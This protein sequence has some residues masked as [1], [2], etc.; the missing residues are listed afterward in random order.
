MTFTLNQQR[1]TILT[2][3]YGRRLGLDS[4][5]ALVGS[6]GHRN[7]VQEYT[8]GS[9][10]TQ[11]VGYGYHSFQLTT[12]STQDFTLGNPY[13]GLEVVIQAQMNGAT[14]L[15]SNWN[16][17][18]ASTAFYIESSEGSTMT[19]INMSS[20]AYV[21]LMG[22]TTDRYQVVGRNPGSTA[23]TGSGASLNGT[24]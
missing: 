9:T 22:V 24:T 5:G 17:K 15:S 16:V 8:S 19:T 11:V 18:R 12:L 10:G 7:I 6:I 4:A 23:V 13:P 3:I 20:R 2:E 1:N 14:N 21:R